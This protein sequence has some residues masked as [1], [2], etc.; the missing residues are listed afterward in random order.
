M[1]R[2]VT[3]SGSGIDE[4]MTKNGPAVGEKIIASAHGTLSANAAAE[5]KAT[6][7]PTLMPIAK[8]NMN[9]ESRLAEQ[10]AHV[11]KTADGSDE[12]GTTGRREVMKGVYD[13]RLLLA[14]ALLRLPRRH[15]LQ[16]RRMIDGGAVVVTHGRETVI[17]I[18]CEI[19]TTL[20]T[21]RHIAS[22]AGLEEMKEVKEVVAGCDWGVR[23]NDLDGGC[24]D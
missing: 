16:D 6:P 18:A 2:S 9:P 10:E 13:H 7:T 23:I 3:E 17:E 11:K 14:V 22:G 12:N 21:I 15:S 8:R 5:G 20:E 19:E 24:E 1:I 4:A